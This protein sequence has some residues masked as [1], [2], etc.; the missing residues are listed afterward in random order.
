VNQGDAVKAEQMLESGTAFAR[1]SGEV[2]RLIVQLKKELSGASKPSTRQA[3]PKMLTAAAPATGS[4]DDW[5][6]F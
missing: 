3:S 6:T 5:E 1:A 4:N 2:G